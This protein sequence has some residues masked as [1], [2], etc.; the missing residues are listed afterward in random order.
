MR[1]KVALV[2]IAFMAM[3]L[4]GVALLA[5][6]NRNRGG[7]VQGA[8]EA[9]LRQNLFTIRTILGQYAVDL[10]K[11]P[12]ALSDLVVAGYLKQVPIDPITGSNDTWVLVMSTD[13]KTPGIENIRSGSHAI[14]SK[15]TAFEDW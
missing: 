13:Q 3:A 7:S 4:I 8:R 11:R 9:V 14:S 1:K 10:H 2:T 5:Y 15:G 6:K 12:Q